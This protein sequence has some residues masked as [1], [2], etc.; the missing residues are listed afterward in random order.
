LKLGRITTETQRATE[1]LFSGKGRILCGTLGPL[2][3][4][5]MIARHAEHASR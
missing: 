5:L 3:F 2:W 1:H 4:E